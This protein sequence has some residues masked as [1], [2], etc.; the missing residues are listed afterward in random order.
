MRLIDADKIEWIPVKAAFA[1][2]KTGE[3]V[4]P[5]KKAEA[6]FKA[7]ID[8]IPTVDAEPVVHGKWI[9]N[10]ID[11]IYVCSEC[12]CTM[13]CCTNYCPNCGARMDGGE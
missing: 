4:S 1:D 3:N 6:T 13:E 8:E 2:K 12:E 10:V 11:G 7:W 9:R 5:E